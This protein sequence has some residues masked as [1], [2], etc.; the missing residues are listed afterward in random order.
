M[1][2]KFTLRGFQLT[3]IIL[4]SLLAGYAFGT[5]K[6]NLAWKS[7]RPII[8]INSSVPPSSQNLDMSLFFQVVDKLNQDY[9]DKSKIDSK[10]ILYGAISGALQSL[11]DPYT[12]FFPP[13][14]NS[15]FKTQLAGEF[16]GIGAELTLSKD[17]IIQVL[18]PLDGSP[19]KKAGIKAGDLILKVDNSDTA[20]WSL[21][22]AVDKIRGARGSTV[23]LTILRD[24]NKN[25]KEL[26]I[27]RDTIQIKSVTGWLKTVSCEGKNCQEQADCSTCASVAYVRLSQFGDKTNEE[28]S[29]KVKELQAGIKNQKN[30]KGVI[31][32]L[33]NNPGGYLNDAVFIASEFI[34]SGVVVQQEDGQGN[35]TQLTVDRSGVFTNVPVEVLINKGSASASEIVSGALR[36]YG[37]AKLIGENSFGK[38]TVQQ[39][40]E[41]DSGASVHISVAKWLTPK[42]TWV[43]KV[44]LKPDIAVNFDEK[45]SADPKKFDNQLQAAI[46]AMIR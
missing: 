11:G 38:G 41:V 28:W 34:K 10:K 4:I 24:K 42:G 23:K 39:A 2:K 1:N 37:R 20:G 29:A 32:D 40:V 31:L 46:S 33:R 5:N 19:A 25:S 21:G 17:N 6:I 18:A 27:K 13:Q 16:S 12:S 26:T 22:Q 8:T 9:Y 44:G 3:A 36:D 15:A 7:Y 43:N 35:R 30:F 45:S 14:Q